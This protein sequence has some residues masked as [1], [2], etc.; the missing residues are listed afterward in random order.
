VRRAPRGAYEEADALGL[1]DL[2]A[3]RRVR[4]SPRGPLAKA[5][6]PDWQAYPEWDEGLDERRAAERAGART[7]RVHG[8]QRGERGRSRRAL[9]RYCNYPDSLSG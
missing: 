3:V 9:A 4:A 2:R 5:D 7:A 8:A 6:H 1:R